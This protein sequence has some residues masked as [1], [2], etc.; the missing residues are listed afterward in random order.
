M[1]LLTSVRVDEEVDVEVDDDEIIAYVLDDEDLIQ[2]VLSAGGLGASAWAS[3]FFEFDTLDRDTA[4]AELQRLMP[5][6]KIE[7][8]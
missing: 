7:L 1:G 2:R 6:I 8:P 5:G 3:A 4:I